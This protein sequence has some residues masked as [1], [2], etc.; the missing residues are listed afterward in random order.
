MWYEV[1]CSQLNAGRIDSF[2][3]FGLIQENPHVKFG[4]RWHGSNHSDGCPVA[5][6]RFSTPVDDDEQAQTVFRPI[7]LARAGGK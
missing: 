2:C 5:A 4:T 3:I 1:D 7:A 6:Q